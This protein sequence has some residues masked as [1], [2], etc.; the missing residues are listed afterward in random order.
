MYVC[1]I[2]LSKVHDMSPPGSPSAENPAAESSVPIP[3]SKS[4][5]DDYVWDVFYHRPT[6]LS[7]WNAIA[8]IGTLCVNFF[9]LCLQGFSWCLVSLICLAETG[10]DCPLPL[11]IRTIPTL[12]LSRKMRLMRTPMVCFLVSNLATLRDQP[13]C[14]QRKSITRTTIQRRIHL[15][16]PVMV[17]VRHLLC[18]LLAASAHVN[19]DMFH[20]QSDYEDMLDD[21]FDEHRWR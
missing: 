1:L 12:I 7:E 6:E 2:P 11:L 13:D 16:M 21:S 9:C 19:L 14:L 10:L 5:G 15:R 4:R 17:A 20:E 18:P 8:N 3:E